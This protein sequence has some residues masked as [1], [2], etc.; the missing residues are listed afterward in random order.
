MGVSAGD[1]TISTIPLPFIESA[2][3]EVLRNGDDM[4]IR[5]LSMTISAG[6]VFAGFGVSVHAQGYDD[7]SCFQ[8]WRERNSIYK[9]AG[10]CF[11]TER[12]R[13]YFGNAGC[14]SYDAGA[15]PLAPGERARIG[16]IVRME[17]IKGCD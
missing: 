2:S 8:L 6:L 16:A 17:R 14:Q 15:L 9:G 12:A 10:Y 4:T 5:R 7:Y 1:A 11:R 3:K 13:Q